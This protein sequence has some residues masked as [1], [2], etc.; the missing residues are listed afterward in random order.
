MSGFVSWSEPLPKEECLVF[1][2]RADGRFQDRRDAGR[3]LVDAVREVLPTGGPDGLLV[4]GLPRGGVVV[5]AEVASGLPAELDVLV[6]RKVSHPSRPELALGAVTAAGAFCNEDLLRRIGVSVEGF[7][8]L[9]AVQ[10][11]EVRR[12]EQLFRAD[13]QALALSGRAVLVVDDGL[14][15]GATAVAA[16]RA[17]R[18][19]GPAWLGFA[20]PV[21]SA[22][23][24]AVIAG[25]VDRLVCPLIPT[26]FL[27]VS[28][29]YR[30]FPQITDEEVRDL[31][32][33]AD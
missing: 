15:T 20:A 18:E 6:V 1:E 28:R 26:S 4:L 5:A 14:A 19:P 2:R 7:Q 10:A 8:E 23:A 21:G 30:D 24:A 16:V 13:R 12:R 31:L 17:V 32:S 22:S 11:E 29:F 27:S 33:R 3:Q 9:A 25:E